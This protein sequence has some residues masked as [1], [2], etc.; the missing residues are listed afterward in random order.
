M[1]VFLWLIFIIVAVISILPLAR[2]KI[3]NVSKKYQRFKYLSM[4]L[5]LWSAITLL[6]FVVI[7]PYVLYYLSL[8][9]YPLLFIITSVLFLAL[10]R[11]LE[12]PILKIYKWFIGIFFL[13]EVGISFTNVKHQLMVEV[14][15]N[16]NLV[17]SD[18]IDM[19][20][21][22][23]F[24]VHTVVCY[25][26]LL[27]VFVL[28]ISKLYENL[29]LDQD[30]MPFL[31]MVFGIVIGVSLNLVH[32]FIYSFTLDPTYL[33]FVIIISL[34]YFVFYIRDIRL[35][36]E[37]NRN[38]FIIDNL[39]EMYLIV[40]QRDEVV[41]ASEEFL[42]SFAIDISN[43]L[44]FN[45]LI[46][47]LEK[48]A[49]IYEN[50]EDIVGGFNNSKRYLHMQVKTIDLPLFKYSGKFYLFY[51]ETKNQVSINDINYVL[52][53]DSM[54]GLY[55]RNYFE[56][57][58]VEIDSTN[59]SYVLSILDL[60]GLK[61]YNDYLGHYAGDQL[62]IDFASRLTE[63]VQKYEYTAIRMGGDEF[64]VISLH[65][66]IDKVESVFKEL[67]ENYHVGSERILFSYGI[68]SKTSA[69]DNLEEV[70]KRAD[71]S[72]YLMKE[73]NK[74]EKVKLKIKLK[75]KQI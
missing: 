14:L 5:A 7:E 43:K 16:A 36:L 2:L 3:F 19:P 18:Y 1:N 52:S 25:L 61:L 15:P 26:M 12:K 69:L 49:V 31:T 9:I 29:K 8:A 32:I 27:F 62:L 34:L 68:S 42:N 51:D 75:K 60:D 24:F 30:V 38:V 73:T 57:K 53:H 4:L 20:H 65:D 22:P 70:F 54:T 17:I 40:N 46:E 74:P 23:L 47:I 48:K 10:L 55:N 66:D 64:L 58:K 72:M 21:G 35:I 28:I 71:K 13:A 41:G 33:A 44:T 63:I 67:R 45:Q 50:S 39:R 11:Y 56:D 59:D 6:R 37:L